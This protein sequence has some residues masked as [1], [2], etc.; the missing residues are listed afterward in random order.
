MRDSGSLL[1][2]IGVPKTS[3]VWRYFLFYMTQKYIKF[4]N[5]LKMEQE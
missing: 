1:A 2:H 5:E 3:H 4:I